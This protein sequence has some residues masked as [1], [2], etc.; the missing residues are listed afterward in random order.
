MNLLE[1]DIIT[2]VEEIDEGW[3]SGVGPGG[4]TGLF[5]CKS[6]VFCRIRSVKTELWSSELC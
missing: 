2:D 6:L 3:W 5:P 1:G 4:K